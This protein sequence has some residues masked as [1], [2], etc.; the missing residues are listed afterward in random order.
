MIT[1]TGSIVVDGSTINPQTKENLG[2]RI[3]TLLSAPYKAA[4]ENAYNKQG[5]LANC[6]E[7]PEICWAL[8]SGSCLL[9]MTR[10]GLGNIAL[11]KRKWTH[12]LFFTEN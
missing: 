10:L 7:L 5:S 1:E 11:N 4:N 2:H 6:L 9:S 8:S 3:I 12:A